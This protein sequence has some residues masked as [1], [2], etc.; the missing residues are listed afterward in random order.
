MFLFSLGCDKDTVGCWSM[1]ALLAMLPMVFVC[2]WR[3]PSFGYN[4]VQLR[5]SPLTCSRSKTR[6]YALH[7]SVWMNDYLRL[8]RD[9]KAVSSWEA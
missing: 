2:K 7:C 1:M 8:Y 5:V 9:Y 6:Q 3:L 4:T